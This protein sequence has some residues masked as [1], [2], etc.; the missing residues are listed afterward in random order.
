MAETAESSSHLPHQS[1]G[2]V[3]ISILAFAAF[4]FAWSAIWEITAHSWPLLVDGAESCFLVPMATG[5]RTSS[6]RVTRWGGPAETLHSRHLLPTC[7]RNEH[8]KN[9]RGI[10]AVGSVLKPLHSILGQCEGS[11]AP[12]ITI[13]QSALVISINKRLRSAG[14]GQSY[15]DD[16]FVQ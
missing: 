6:S 15:H 7:Q 5:E 8:V 11:A 16:A 10:I 12:T 14:L 2:R 9:E 3:V 1:L 4:V 13:A